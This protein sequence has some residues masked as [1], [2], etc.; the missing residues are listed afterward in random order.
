MSDQEILSDFVGNTTSEWK[1]YTFSD[2]IEVNNYPSLEKGKEQTY[3]AMKNLYPYHRKIK[4]KS[5]KEYKYSAPRF[6]NNDTLFPKMSRCLEIGKTA[7]VDILEEG[8]IAF[9]STEFMVMR[10]K[11]NT[12]LPKFVYYAVR[13]EDIR[14]HAL[15]W[16]TGSTARRQR[17]S[18]DLFDNLTIKVPPIEEQREI[19][20]FLDAIDTKI[21][22]NIHTNSLL[23]E[24]SQTLFRSWFVD[25]DLY[26]DEEFVYDPELEMEYPK[27]WEKRP[28]NSVANFLNG[29]RWQN[30]EAQDEHKETL[31]VI[32]I[33]ELRNGI[34]EDSDKVSKKQAPEKYYIE[35]GDVVFSWSASLVLDVWKGD[36]GFLNQHLFKVTSEDYPRWFYYSWINHHLNRFQRIA[37]SKKTTMGHI[38]RGHLEEAKVLVPDEKTLDNMTEIMAPIFELQVSNGEENATLAELRD[39]LLP[40]LMLGQVRFSPGSN[41]ESNP[42]TEHEK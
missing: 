6:K 1:E 24:L 12:I 36:E 32:K 2:V 20:G 19:I 3:V 16:A 37:E 14:K 9:G 30:H 22:N 26:N 4:D 25:F 5:K 8:E 35:A 18:T 39:T 13:R 21:E 28:L 34:Q 40:K 23:E 15:S 27:H 17:I 29:I 11:D 7:Y 42:L 38:K 31:P 10:P 33:E 41:N